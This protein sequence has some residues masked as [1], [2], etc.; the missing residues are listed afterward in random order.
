[1]TAIP[2]KKI[3][4]PVSRAAVE[5]SRRSRAFL[6]SSMGMLPDHIENVERLICDGDRPGFDQFLRFVIAPAGA[7]RHRARRGR[8]RHVEAG[9]AENDGGCGRRAGIGDRLS[10]HRRMRLGWLSVSGL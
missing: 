10:N 5:M 2:M 8:H 9:V 3:A 6:S 7:N 4:K 1:M